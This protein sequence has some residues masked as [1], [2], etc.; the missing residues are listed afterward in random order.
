MSNES[1]EED[2][3]TLG[4]CSYCKTHVY[5][6]EEYVKKNGAVLHLECWKQRHNVEEELNFDE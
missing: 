3:E 6:D 5:S 2:K 4:Y 1:N